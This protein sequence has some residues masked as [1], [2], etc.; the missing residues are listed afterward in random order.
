MVATGLGIPTNR[1]CCSIGS[2]GIMANSRAGNTTR[3]RAYASREC[4]ACTCAIV[5]VV[6]LNYTTIISTVVMGLC[7]CNHILQLRHIH[8]ICRIN[9]STHIG[10]TVAAIIQTAARQA[11]HS[12]RVKMMNGHTRIIHHG[13]TR[14]QTAVCAQIHILCQLDRQCI[15]A[16]GDH[17][18]IVIRQCTSS[19]ALDIGCLAQFAIKISAAIAGKRQ[20]LVGQII[21]LPHVHRI[22]II[23][24]G[25][26][27]SQRGRRDSAVRGLHR[28][29]H[30]R[31]LYGGTAAIQGS[32]EGSICLLVDLV[33]RSIGIHHRQ[34]CTIG[35]RLRIHRISESTAALRNRQAIPRSQ[36]ELI[37]RFHQLITGN[38]V[39]IAAGSGNKA[40]VIDGIGHTFCRGKAIAGSR[41]WRR[42]SYFAVSAC[43][44]CSRAHIEFNFTSRA[45]AADLDFSA[46]AIDEIHR[47]IGFNKIYFRIIALQIPAGIENIA[48]GSGIA[49]LRIRQ[50]WCSL[51]GSNRASA[52]R[53]VV[54]SR[55]RARHIGQTRRVGSRTIGIL[56][57]SNHISERHFDTRA[58]RL[59]I[60]FTIGMLIHLIARFIGVFHWQLRTLRQCLRIGRNSDFGTRLGQLNTCARVQRKSIAVFH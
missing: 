7:P 52:S 1:Y 57:G 26:N 28:S 23:H 18:N 16:I 11:H 46:S 36:R 29:N 27:V 10:N 44:K 56:H 12:G 22:R 54:S 2:I 5:V 39:H 21:E 58:I 55:Q 34:L 32:I 31:G 35:Y 45:I 53:G 47:V 50:R 60:E 15:C 40:G 20:W 33:A 8:S 19:A 48:Y 49:F 51:S 25:L 38:T 59:G 3:L 6:A 13:V 14:F 24:P 37:A 9:S 30:I 42:G 43:S 17:T 41:C 4:I